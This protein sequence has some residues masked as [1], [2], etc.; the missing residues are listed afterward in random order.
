MT[1]LLSGCGDE[2]STAPAST[3]AAVLPVP[4]EDVPPCRYADW[5]VL[6]DI[7]IMCFEMV[8]DEVTAPEAAPALT[9]LVFGP[10]GTL[11]FARTALGEVWALRDEDGDGFMEPPI[12]VADGLTLPTRL[13]FH[14]DALYVLAGDGV[15]RLDVDSDGQ[16]RE[17]TIL[18][19]GLGAETGFWPGS[20]G[21]GP[22]D[23]LYVGVG[24]DCVICDHPGLQPGRL[25]SYALDGSDE[26]VEA[27]GFQFPADFAWHPDSGELWIVDRGRILPER[28]LFGPRDEINRFVPGADYGFPLCYDDRVPDAAFGA[29]EADCTG[30]VGP[31]VM[32]PYQSAPAGIVFYLHDAFPTWKGDLLVAQNGSWDRL[33][34]NGYAVVVTGFDGPVPDGTQDVIAPHQEP[35]FVPK[36]ITLYSLLGQGFFP[37]RPV[38]VAVS[39]EGWIY[40]ALQEGRIVRFRPRP[41]E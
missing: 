2:N 9:G 14:K 40:V 32:Y 21:I 18:V 13:A 38:D 8:F 3:G 28:G 12:R 30:T 29:T 23:R 19:T 22:D 35:R 16:Y 4:A 17:Q 33:E 20:V 36:T 11:F 41:A 5:P 39:P 37:Y 1:I 34:P 10:D 15:V 31:E 25:L 27:T 7:R 26:R 24:A 6:Y